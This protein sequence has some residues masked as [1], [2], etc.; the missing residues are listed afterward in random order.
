VAVLDSK[1]DVSAE[2]A[3]IA[4][5]ITDVLTDAPPFVAD[6]RGPYGRY[7]KPVLDRC[8]AVFLLALSS[9]LMLA[10]AVLIRR[11]L[12]NGVLYR[13]L[14]V[15]YGGQSFV[16]YKFRT[17]HHDRRRQNVG[18]P[19]AERRR[20]HKVADDPRHTELG[21]VLRRLS[22]DELPQLWNVVRGDM[23]LVGPRPELHEVVAARQ[24]FGH[25]RHGVKPGITGPWQISEHRGALLHENMEL[26]VEYVD[27]MSFRTDCR[28][29]FR[30][31]HAVCRRRL[32]S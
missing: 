28:I 15:G 14:R 26:D 11:R 17:M 3:A 12:G 4:E 7:A 1:I 32:G 30:T 20:C 29:L 8:F 18:P 19:G 21:R 5:P 16:M 10:L 22:L 13:Q 23:S 27:S 31:I 9:P 2:S 25:P 24:L 6:E